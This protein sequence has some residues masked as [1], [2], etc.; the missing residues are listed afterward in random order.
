LL[1]SVLVIPGPLFFHLNIWI[2]ISGSKKHCCWHFHW[3]YIESISQFGKNLLVY[4][5]KSSYPQNRY[6]F[7]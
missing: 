3:N 4:E 5:F 2:S 1:R 7:I 6:L